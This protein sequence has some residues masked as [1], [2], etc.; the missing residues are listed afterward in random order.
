MVV[1]VCNAIKEKDLRAAV[2][3]GADRPSQVY[4][5]LGRKPKCGQCLAFAQT[6]IRSEVAT[7]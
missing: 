4:A 6:I 2:R 5:L 7:A 1:C 3:T